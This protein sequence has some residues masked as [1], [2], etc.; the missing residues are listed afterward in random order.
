[1]ARYPAQFGIDLLGK[2]RQRSPV[3]AAPRSQ[4]SRD[5]VGSGIALRPGIDG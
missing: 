1:V 3:A 5:S 2:P 4:E